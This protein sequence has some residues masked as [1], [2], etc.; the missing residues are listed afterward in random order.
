MSGEDSN[1]LLSRIRDPLQGVFPSSPF[2]ELSA[3]LADFS[4]RI[5]TRTRPFLYETPRQAR[6]SGLYFLLRAISLCFLGQVLFEFIDQGAYRL[7][8]GR[9]AA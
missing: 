7:I 9:E 2:G 4:R 3:F 6:F 8:I 5:C 1:T